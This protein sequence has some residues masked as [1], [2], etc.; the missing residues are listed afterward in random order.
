MDMTSPLPPLPAHIETVSFDIFDTLVHRFVYAPADVFDAVRSRLMTSETA[1][2]YPKL[3]ENFP[4]IRR[5]SEY[6]ARLK[7]AADYQGNMEINFEEIYDQLAADYAV[8]D[9]TRRLLQETEL[10]L[11]R[12]FLYR[13]T[14]GYRQYRQAVDAGKK[15]VFI[16]DMY[17]SRDFLTG[18]LNSLGYEQAGDDTVFVSGE[19]RC[20]KHSSE[21]YRLVRDRLNLNPETWLHFGDNMHADVHAAA[22]AGLTGRHADWSKVENIPRHTADIADAVPES[23][24]QAMDLPQY[25]AKYPLDNDYR[26]IG[27][28]VFGPLMF[29]FYVWMQHHLAQYRPDKILFFA[30]DAY[31]IRQIYQMLGNNMENTEYVYLSRKSVYPLSLLDFPLDRLHFLIGGRSK[32]TIADIGRNYHLDL[33]QVQT[34][35]TQFGLSPDTVLTEANY[36]WVY[37]FFATCFQEIAAQ[38]RETRN[39]FAPYFTDMAE[40][41]EKVAVIDI[42]WSG[43]IQAALSRILS[44]SGNR[45]CL[46]GFYLGL[47]PSAMQNMRNNCTMTGW[48]CNLHERPDYARILQSGG[49]ELLEFVLTSPDGSTLAYEQDGQGKIVPVLE[50][51]NTQEQD[52]EYKAL[53]VQEGVLQFIRNHAYLLEQFPLQA[54]NSLAWAKPFFNLTD[55]PS[56]EQIALLADLTHSDA[57]GDNSSR[58]VLAEKLPLR[59]RLLRTKKYRNAKKAAFWKKAFYYRNHLSPKKYRG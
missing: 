44:G 51:K 54:L 14:T 27:H 21:L 19:H 3:I 37:Q 4:A 41:K 42:G 17:L 53:E 47:F 43:N 2:R 26:K 30:R 55:N 33:S 13:S 50:Q 28:D 38:S 39:R 9:E 25:R 15:V 40:G 31:L 20:N 35:L 32:R 52:Y 46:K 11:E 10:E 16:S 24:I 34:N 5:D 36:H 45:A 22:Q 57:A 1:L 6:K 12:T 29:G 58:L 23:V 56:R 59:D 49:A 18:M 48:L 7:R 8:P